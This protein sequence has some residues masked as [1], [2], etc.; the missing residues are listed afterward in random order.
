MKSAWLL[1]LIGDKASPAA[2]DSNEV[3]RAQNRRCYPLRG[4]D[5]LIWCLSSSPSLSVGFFLSKTKPWML[6]GPHHM[7]PPL[8][9]YLEGGMGLKVFRIWSS[10]TRF[11]INFLHTPVDNT[12]LAFCTKYVIPVG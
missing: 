2:H 8:T 10:P 1:H 3:A 12:P 4:K 9:E 6:T 7:G 5:G 11:P